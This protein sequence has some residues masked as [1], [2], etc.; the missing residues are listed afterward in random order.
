LNTLLTSSPELPLGLLSAKL[1][2]INSRPFSLFA[3]KPLGFCLLSHLALQAFC[4]GPR[5]PLTFS[6]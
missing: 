4:L 2:S 5:L 1:L 6:L 3:R